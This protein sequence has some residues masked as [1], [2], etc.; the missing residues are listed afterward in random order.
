[1]AKTD[2]EI[3]GSY[4]LIVLLLSYATAGAAHIGAFSV[5]LFIFG[6]MVVFGAMGYSGTSYAPVK[7][8]PWDRQSTVR[9]FSYFLGATLGAL[10]GLLIAQPLGPVSENGEV[11]W[12][13]VMSR[14]TIIFLL[15][16]L[17]VLSV[18][19]WRRGA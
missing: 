14:G 10:I 6:F 8:K 15:E 7:G 16:A 5:V 19:W 12:G 1:M 18:R 3:P 17:V 9:V 4:S 2:S 13:V 11:S